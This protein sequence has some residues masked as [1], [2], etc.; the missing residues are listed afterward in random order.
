M[1]KAP[2]ELHFLIDDYQYRWCCIPFILRL[3]QV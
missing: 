2:E 1:F 3:S